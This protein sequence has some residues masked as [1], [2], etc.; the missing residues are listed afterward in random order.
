M[1]L[2]NLFHKDIYWDKFASQYQLLLF[3]YYFSCI[4]Q[5]P[6]ES[7]FY[8]YS[9]HSHWE[10]LYKEKYLLTHH[11]IY[12]AS[13]LGYRKNSM[14]GMLN[15]V[16]YPSILYDLSQK[17]IKEYL[18]HFADTVMHSSDEI[19]YDFWIAICFF[20]KGFAEMFVSILLVWE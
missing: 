12:T 15:D 6:K 19:I 4:M 9:F 2:E 13:L 17:E 20:C 1:T 7:N 14:N 5:S 11:R 18:R 3:L 16:M 10:T 8:H